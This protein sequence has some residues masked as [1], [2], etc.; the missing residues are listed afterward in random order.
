MYFPSEAFLPNFLVITIII[1]SVRNKNYFLFLTF[2]SHLSHS[3]IIWFC[4]SAFTVTNLLILRIFANILSSSSEYSICSSTPFYSSLSSLWAL[5]H[6]SCTS[7][8]CSYLTTVTVHRYLVILHYYKFASEYS[9][10]WNTPFFH[11]PILSPTINTL[12]YLSL[13]S[14]NR[15]RCLESN[16]K[17]WNR[18]TTL[19][20]T[21]ST[22]FVIW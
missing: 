4:E 9:F 19:F 10:Y 3:V 1:S 5:L 7:Q 12:L 11:R 18:N 21:R 16:S 15:Y 8:F 13:T 20:T 22:T 6:L 14:R 17:A 2:L